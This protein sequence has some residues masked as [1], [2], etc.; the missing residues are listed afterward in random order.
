MTNPHHVLLNTALSRGS[1]DSPILVILSERSESKNPPKLRATMREAL[2]ARPEGDP[3]T[4]SSDSFAQGDTR[5][6]LR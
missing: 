2:R 6:G 5:G 1:V 3:S 4:R